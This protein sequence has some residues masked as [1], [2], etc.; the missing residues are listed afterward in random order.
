MKPIDRFKETLKERNLDHDD[1][2]AIM[3]A[4]IELSGEAKLEGINVMVELQKQ[5]K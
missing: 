2:F 1:Y 5:V 3:Y 4:A